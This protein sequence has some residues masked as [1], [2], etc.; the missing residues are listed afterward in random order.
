MVSRRQR[1]ELSSRPACRL[2]QQPASA[3]GQRPDDDADN[4]VATNGGASDDDDDADNDVEDV[5]APTVA[6]IVDARFAR[7]WGAVL[8]LAGRLNFTGVAQLLVALGLLD[9]LVDADLPPLRRPPGRMGPSCHAN[10]VA[11]VLGVDRAELRRTLDEL[12]GVVLTAHVDDER[13]LPFALVPPLR[14]RV[15]AMFEAADP[16]EALLPL[17]AAS[18]P[19]D[20]PAAV[21]ALVVPAVA[22][23]FATGQPCSVLLRGSDRDDL[24]AVAHDVA[25]AVGARVIDPSVVL[26]GDI[27]WLMRVLG[28]RGRLVWIHEN[29]GRRHAGLYAPSIPALEDDEPAVRKRGQPSAPALVS[30]TL[31]DDSRPATPV[32]LS[33]AM[34]V[35]Q[36]AP[37]TPARR[38]ARIVGS[39]RASAATDRGSPTRSSTVSSRSAPIAP[40]SRSSL[41]SRGSGPSRQRRTNGEARSSPGCSR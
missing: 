19:V 8:G 6:D 9:A 17:P 33:S 16:L 26:V 29:V 14:R 32:E 10:L 31:S 36:V 37:P 41:P 35:V 12:D 1:S 15:R 27:D 11:R 38:R 30:F 24:R 39:S 25:A 28:P 5:P 2:F 18:A 3:A 20:L 34:I 21:G 13:C 7:G 22:T 40:P 4:D 23:A